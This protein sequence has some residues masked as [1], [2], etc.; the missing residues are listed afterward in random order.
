MHLKKCKKNTS[1][2]SFLES[3]RYFYVPNNKTYNLIKSFMWRKKIHF[4]CSDDVLINNILRNNII[5]LYMPVDKKLL[6]PAPETVRVRTCRLGEQV[7][8][9]L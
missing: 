2:S 3:L 5:D 9:F 8:Y 7:R 6:I 1:S 4:V